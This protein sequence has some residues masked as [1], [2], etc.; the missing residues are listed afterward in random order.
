[1]YKFFNY[2][3]V[4]FNYR[5]RPRVLEIICKAQTKPPVLLGLVVQ[6]PGMTGVTSRS[7]GWLFCFD[8]FVKDSVSLVLEAGRL[9]KNIAFAKRIT[10]SNYFDDLR[11]R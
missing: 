4:P 1:M 11:Y 9:A 10:Y 8:F 7:A 6:S 3:K 5:W 2:K